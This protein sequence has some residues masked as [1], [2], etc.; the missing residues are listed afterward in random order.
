MHQFVID[1]E[2]TCFFLLV[3]LAGFVDETIAAIAGRSIHT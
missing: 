2:S 1:F 3:L